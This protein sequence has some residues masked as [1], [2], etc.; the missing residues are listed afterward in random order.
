MYTEYEA[1]DFITENDVEFI[2]LQ[3]CDI[4]GNLKNTS[5]MA[6]ELPKA[7]QTG[8]SFDASNV[9]GFSTVDQSDLF[10]VPDP[11]SL[12]VLPW[13]PQQGGV[14]RFLCDVK[15]ADGTVYE[16]DSRQILKRSLQKAKKLG[17]DF[18][19]GPE[20]EFYLFETDEFGKPSLKPHDTAA[21]YDVAPLDKGENVRRSICL[22]LK[23]MGITVESSHHESGPGQ[24]EIDIKYSD[25]LTAADQFITLK[26]VVNAIAQQNG[27]YA[28]FMPKPIDGI[29][30]SGLHINM[31]LKKDGVNVF[32]SGSP[33]PEA[34]AFIAGILAH[35]KGICLFTNP[36]VN[37]YKRLLSGFE[38][39]RYISWSHQ[40]RSQLVRIPDA[41]GEDH[42][43]E[44]RC[45]DP[46]TNPYL[47]FALLLEAGLYGIQNNLELPRE[48][49]LDL[50]QKN[51]QMPEPLPSN[52]K[53]A[54][55][56]ASENELIKKVLGKK[57][58]EKYA[59]I[60]Q[61]E[62][63]SYQATVSEWEIKHYF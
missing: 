52:L 22:T 39:P 43:M 1:M 17:Y 25:G 42:R 27:L 55:Q 35:I 28:S 50:Y 48:V 11:A 56:A 9:K 46:R 31:S 47:S 3:F 33:T 37:S 57:V 32:G 16:A 23:K 24:H 36:L 34:K 21:Y 13:R 5:I 8:I 6:A 10:L 15:K 53:E 4:L 63:E 59:A 45:P 58:F 7:F 38:A 44:L 54:L 30:G 20:C 26:A 51:Q 14:V 60:K 62:W 49:R 2:R 19:V 12:A 18:M 61:K 29:S 40:N 41:H